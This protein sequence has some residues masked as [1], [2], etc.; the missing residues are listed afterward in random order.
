MKRLNFHK[1]DDY[2]MDLDYMSERLNEICPYLKVTQD[3]VIHYLKEWQYLSKDGSLAMKG[4]YSGYFYDKKTLT[5]K[6]GG[7][8][9]QI[10]ISLFEMMYEIDKRE[11]C[12]PVSLINR[13]KKS[14]SFD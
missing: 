14:L 6:G 3:E 4:K 12:D 8:F 13:I 7:Y 2:A 10:F 5:L 11:K 1:Y 9:I